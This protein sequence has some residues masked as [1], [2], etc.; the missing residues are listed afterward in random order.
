M[1]NENAATL[2]LSAFFLYAGKGSFLTATHTITTIQTFV[3]G[4]TS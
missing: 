3:T 2:R 1:L 4:T